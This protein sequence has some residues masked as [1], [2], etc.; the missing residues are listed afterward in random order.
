MIIQEKRYTKLSALKIENNVNLDK[1]KIYLKN[2]VDLEGTAFDIYKRCSLEM[3]K[4]INVIM[5]KK[6]IPKKQRGEVT[7]FKKRK[8]ADS[9][10]LSKVKNL[11]KL[12]DY[13]RMM[14][15]PGYPKTFIKKRNLKISFENSKIDKNSIIAKAIITLS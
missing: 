15:I 9:Q 13:I 6:I 4:M 14:D 8:P 12:H 5:S 1:G 10:L 11:S 3:I 2:R 7:I